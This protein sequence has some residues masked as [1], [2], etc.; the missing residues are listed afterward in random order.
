MTNKAHGASLEREGRIS[1]RHPGMLGGAMSWRD[2]SSA[3]RDGTSFQARI[4]GHGEDNVIAWQNGLVD[5]DGRDCCAWTFTSEQEPPDCWTDGWCWAVNEDGVQSVQPT[6][7]KPLTD[8][9][10][11]T[12]VPADGPT[13]H[14][15]FIPFEEEVNRWLDTEEAVGTC[16]GSC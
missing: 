12:F 6:H 14:A 16:Q 3:P 10:D 8:V 9:Q 2:I 1:P 11:D 15:R 13:T 4:P 7:W 5:E